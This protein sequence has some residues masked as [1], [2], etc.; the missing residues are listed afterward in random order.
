MP[1]RAASRL[2]TTGTTCLVSLCPGDMAD[3]EDLPFVPLGTAV[4]VGAS[5]LPA[6]SAG[7]GESAPATSPTGAAPHLRHL[8]ALK[9]PNPNV[10]R[11]AA[12]DSIEDRY[13]NIDGKIR[14]QFFF[15]DYVV[16]TNEVLLR[17][18]CCSFAFAQTQCMTVLPDTPCPAV[19][20]RDPE[21]PWPPPQCRTMCAAV[22]M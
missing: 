20:P 22:I 19:Q 6:G 1:V 8:R 12:K 16:K 9:P 14:E 21:S 11:F 4:D 15:D 5:V 10:D 13:T 18:V 7:S 3:L 2:S 17:T